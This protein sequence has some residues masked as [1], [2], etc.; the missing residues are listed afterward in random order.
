MKKSASKNRQKNIAE[1]RSC[2]VGLIIESPVL[3][4]PTVRDWGSH[5]VVSNLSFS[6]IQYKPFLNIICFFK[7]ILIGTDL[8]TSLQKKS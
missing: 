6:L 7:K 4:L 3:L 8:F 2:I 1:N 5:M